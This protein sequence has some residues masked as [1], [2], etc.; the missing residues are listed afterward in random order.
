MAN[1]PDIKYA[2]PDNDISSHPMPI[3]FFFLARFA[4]YTSL[5]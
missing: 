4:I 5:L 2:K 1:K 3:A